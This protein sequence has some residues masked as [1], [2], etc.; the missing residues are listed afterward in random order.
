[1]TLKSS[2]WPP[3]ISKLHFQRK[4]PLP[5]QTFFIASALGRLM[6][7]KVQN[8]LRWFCG[9]QKIGQ[10]CQL[11]SAIWQTEHFIN[12]TLFCGFFASLE[13]ESASFL[14]SLG[15]KLPFGWICFLLGKFL[16]LKFPLGDIFGKFYLPWAIFF[17][18]HLVTLFLKR[19]KSWGQ[20]LLLTDPSSFSL[21]SKPRRNFP[22]KK[23]FSS[24]ILD[25]KNNL[26]P[27]LGFFGE[28]NSFL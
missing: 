21:W 10:I 22:A 17:K 23:C 25:A 27:N 4:F 1:M 20:M 16:R 11:R 6:V 9:R 28:E 8:C 12:V 5:C 7:K 19:K 3:L 18:N 24:L 15:K 2:F 14:T 26:M 13:N